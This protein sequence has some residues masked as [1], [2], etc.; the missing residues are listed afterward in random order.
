MLK[1]YYAPGACSMASHITLEETGAPYDTQ[2]LQ[3]AK[4]EQKSEAYLKVNPRG[5]VPAL[6]V[7]GTVLT[8]NT[9][10]LTYLAKRFAEKKLFPPDPIGEARCISTMAWL[11]N[12]V[13]PCFTHIG[14]PERFS[15]D[16]STHAAL[17]E[18]GRK[19]FWANLQEI[20][21]LIGGG[22]WFFGAQFTT[23]D[24]YA[25]VFYGWGLRIALPMTE[26]KNYTAWKERMLARPAVRKILEREKS[27]LLQAA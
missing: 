1:L 3:F 14:R 10:I 4:T 13:H 21:G 6:E 24:P 7:D 2:A 8:E 25:L 9:A 12:T 22:P 16:V 11:S 5:K 19:S 20:D 15:D 23:C 26:L 18:M 17:K 27:I